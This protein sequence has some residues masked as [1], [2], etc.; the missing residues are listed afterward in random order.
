V[1]EVRLERDGTLDYAEMAGKIG[2]RTKV[3]A[4]GMASN[5][6]GTVNDVARA[7]ELSGAVGSWLVLDAV[8]FAPHFTLDVQALD[9]DVLM[10]SAYK[11]YG[12]HVGILYC[13]PGLLE[14]LRTDRLRTQDEAPPYRIETG[15]LN[16]AAIAG[17]K[18]AIEY[19]AS[20]GAGQSLRGRIVD[21]FARLGA[22]ERGLAQ[23]YFDGVRSVPGVT[24]WGPDFSVPRRAP[25]VSIT[26]EGV[27]ASEA[28]ARLGARGIAVWDG[29]FYAARAVEV[30][31]LAKRG[32]LLRTGVSMYTTAEEI[33]RLLEGVAAIA[34]GKT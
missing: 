32:G 31:G 13:R 12:P 18:A 6:L 24:V 21:A 26:I 2:P 19:L 22:H 5:A 7:R 4:V 8:H 23:R 33:D 20:F 10:C 28:A 14:G 16:H 25:T 3:V 1:R 15:T 9:C 17:V 34:A 27:P 29:H 30:L 11:F